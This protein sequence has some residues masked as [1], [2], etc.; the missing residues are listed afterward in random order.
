MDESDGRERRWSVCN[1]VTG[2]LRRLKVNPASE[3]RGRTLPY[4]PGGALQAD[5]S[6]LHTC[7]DRARTGSVAVPHLPLNSHPPY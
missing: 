1:N 4:K 6:D 7:I 3:R 5:L 2:E